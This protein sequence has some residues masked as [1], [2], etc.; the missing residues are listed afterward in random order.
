MIQNNILA[1]KSTDFGERI[2]RC[3]QFLTKEKKEYVISKQIKIL[4]ATIKSSKE[5]Q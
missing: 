3:H 2:V 5:N 1:D 4:T